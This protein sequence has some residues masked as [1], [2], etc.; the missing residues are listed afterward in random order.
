ME[1]TIRSHIQKTSTLCFKHPLWHVQVPEGREGFLRHPEEA[2]RAGAVHMG[3][4]DIMR[5]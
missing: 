3:L 2:G 4:C 5:A 1:R